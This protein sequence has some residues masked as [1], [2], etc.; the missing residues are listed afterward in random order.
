MKATAALFKTHAKLPDEF[1]GVMKAFVKCLKKEISDAKQ[2]GKVNERDADPIPFALYTILAHTALMA[3]NIFF[4]SYLILQWNL[5]ARSCN[6]ASV[7]LHH[8]KV[9]GDALGCMFHSTKGDPTGANKTTKH[10][11][12]TGWNSLY[13]HT[14]IMPKR[15]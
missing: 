6:V 14:H 2:R 3:G 5:M 13:M 15:P 4:W 10:M 8:F 12:A 11:Y 1:D 7:G 9:A